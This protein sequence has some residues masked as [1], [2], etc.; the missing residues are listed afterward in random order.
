MAVNKR[1][2]SNPPVERAIPTL[3]EVVELYA[4]TSEPA[5]PEGIGKMLNA[6]RQDPEHNI[7]IV[8]PPER[9]LIGFLHAWKD[10]DGKC[11]IVQDIVVNPDSPHRGKGIA[12]ALLAE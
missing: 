10:A 9:K 6:A 12:R 7:W 8:H 2:E 1:Q 5:D 11:G 4:L 3:A